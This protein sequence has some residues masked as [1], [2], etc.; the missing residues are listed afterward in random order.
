MR[1]CLFISPRAALRR[2]VD[3]TRAS[4]SVETVLILPLLLWVFVGTFVF[5]DAF[6]AQTSS[7][8]AAYTISDMLSRETNAVSSDYIDGLNEVFDYLIRTRYDTSIRVSSIGWDDDA[9][10]YTVI[11]SY[12][13]RGGGALTDTLANQAEGRLPDIPSG[14]TLV[15][16]ETR[17]AYIPPF[18]VGIGAQ[19]FNE[20][21]ASRPRFAPQLVFDGGSV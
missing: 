7:S 12:A 14:D 5:F 15:L 6:R 9:G 16:V 20:F 3:E 18:N 13:T 10:K 21:V 4:F 1:R 2:F 8:K 19:H 17:L 11:W